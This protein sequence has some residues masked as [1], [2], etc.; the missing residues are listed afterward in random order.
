MIFLSKKGDG[1]HLETIK[2]LKPSTYIDSL[3]LTQIF[4]VLKTTTNYSF[5]HIIKTLK[6]LGILHYPKCICT[7]YVNFFGANKW[8]IICTKVTKIIL[9]QLLLMTT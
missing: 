9:L 4:L 7:T 1:D 5:E 2:P 6:D 3:S 8:N